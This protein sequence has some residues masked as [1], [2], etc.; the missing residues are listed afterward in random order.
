MQWAAPI[1][2]IW[3]HKIQHYKEKAQLV[4]KI[5]IIASAVKMRAGKDGAEMIAEAA[6]YSAS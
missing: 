4:R 2:I 1:A 3:G 5:I 6:A